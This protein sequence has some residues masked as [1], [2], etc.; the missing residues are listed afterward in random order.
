[1]QRSGID[2]QV[3]HLTQDTNG[4]V[5]HSQLD[6]TKESKDVSP[7]PAGDHKALI[8]RRAQRHSKQHKN[9]FRV[10]CSEIFTNQPFYLKSASDYPLD[11]NMYRRSTNVQNEPSNNVVCATS[12][13]SDQ[14]V[15]T[16]SLTRA[17]ASYLNILWVLS[18]WL[19][20]IWSFQ[21]K[22]RLHRLVWVYT[23]QNATLLEI[24]CHGSNLSVR[25]PEG[26]ILVYVKRVVIGIWWME[27]RAIVTSRECCYWSI[28]Y[29]YKRHIN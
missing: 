27:L 12:K 28:L 18:Y 21:L 20:T 24:T 25:V 10:K 11:R 3:P 1:M 26:Q 29:M 7:F 23:C 6:T 15:H 5:T 16:R 22:R 19:Y 9:L 2:T 8:N 13:D 4:K 17:F 14:S